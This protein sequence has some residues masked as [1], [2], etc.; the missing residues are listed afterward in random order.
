MIAMTRRLLLL[1]LPVALAACGLGGLGAPSFTLD[2]VTVVAEPGANRNR[3][4]AVDLV[5]IK[6]SGALDQIA[7]LSAGDWFQRKPQFLR[8]FPRGLAIVSWEPV[9]ALSLPERVLSDDEIDGAMAGIV[10]ADF[11]TPGDHRARL[12][13]AG[14]LRLRLMADDFVVETIRP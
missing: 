5:L 13:S 6:D 4:V 10:F 12:E 8:D 14:A 2:S 9:P 7:T 11:V 3:P 1:A